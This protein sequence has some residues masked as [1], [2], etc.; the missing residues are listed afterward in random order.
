MA[1]GST[2]ETVGLATAVLSA[3]GTGNLQRLVPGGDLLTDQVW[4]V[5]L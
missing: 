5:L 2:M 4:V 1:I 3:A